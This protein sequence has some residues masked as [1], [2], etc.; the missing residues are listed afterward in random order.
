MHL[1]ILPLNEREQLLTLCLKL[2]KFNN[3]INVS[4]VS[5]TDMTRL[6]KKKKIKNI[7]G[8]KSHANLLPG[9]F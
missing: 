3:H 4:G 2:N 1:P 7:Q 9:Q 8:I 5:K 6:K